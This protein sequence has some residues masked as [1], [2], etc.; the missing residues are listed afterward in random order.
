MKEP[1]ESI[2]LSKGLD[3]WL[4]VYI[5]PKL[6]AGV[7]PFYSWDYKNNDFGEIAIK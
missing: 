6:F 4:T 2:D 7:S 5:A 1:I 3:Q